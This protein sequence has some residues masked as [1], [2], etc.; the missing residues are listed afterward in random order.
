MILLNQRD[1]PMTT[2]GN[3]TVTIARGGCL[4]TDLSMFS[5]WYGKYRSPDW[6]AKNLRFTEQGY[7]Y[8]KSIDDADL[9][10]NFEYRY[11]KR[12]DKKIKDILYSEDNAC[13]LQVNNGLHWV[14]LV[15]YSKI[16]GYRIADPYYGDI[17]YLKKRYPNI[18]GFAE[19]SR[20]Y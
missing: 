16:Y 17:V 10:F 15:G 18:T 7:L 6:M 1:Y 5:H 12:D 3:S 20:R 14:A 9:P 11:Y 8:W 4:I 2:L 19:V 13:V